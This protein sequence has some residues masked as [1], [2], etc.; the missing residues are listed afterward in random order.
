MAQVI[1]KDDSITLMKALAI[2]LMVAVH[3]GIANM[4]ANF[5]CSFHMPLFFIVSGYCFKEK[6]VNEFGLFIW[7]K[8]KGLYIPF[9]LGVGSFILLHNFFCK[10]GFYTVE[11][12]PSSLVVCTYSNSEIIKKLF[13]S[14]IAMNNEEPLIGGFWFLRSLLVASILSL[15][16]IKIFRNPIIVCLIFLCLSFIMAIKPESKMLFWISHF[17]IVSFFFI[18]GFVWKKS[19][20]HIKNRRL[21]TLLLYIFIF[22][23]SLYFPVSTLSYK[24]LTIPILI[25]CGLFGTLATH[26]LCIVF[27]KNI[28]GRIRQYFLYVV[29]HTLSIL[30]LHFVSF[31]LLSLLLIGI[32]NLPFIEL[33]R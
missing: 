17:F 9:V 12:I 16:F 18:S 33:S 7:K 31:K 4:P 6:Y 2:S 11:N 14:I 21:L 23:V 1:Q 32:Y 19:N 22:I 27:Q 29:N 15:I 8:I 25:C 13:F 3:A 28:K 30:A 5:I 24:P 20:I 10:I 26:C